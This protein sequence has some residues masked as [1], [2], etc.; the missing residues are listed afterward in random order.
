VSVEQLVQVPGN[1]AAEQGPRKERFEAIPR[2]QVL[3]GHGPEFDLLG[4]GQRLGTIQGP[5]DIGRG[6]L[7]PL[8]GVASHPTQVTPTRGHARGHLTGR[9]ALAQFAGQVAA[10]VG[11]RAQFLQRQAIEAQR[12]GGRGI[13]A[14]AAGRID[15]GRVVARLMQVVPQA[16]PPHWRRRRSRSNPE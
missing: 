13:T 1:L 3:K 5:G 9:N 7:D 10:P 11:E 16:P 8:I 15:T 12:L 4:I 14:C 6:P 2:G